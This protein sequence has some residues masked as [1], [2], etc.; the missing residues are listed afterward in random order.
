MEKQSIIMCCL[1]IFSRSFIKHA[2]FHKY[3]EVQF[4]ILSESF[5]I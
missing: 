1:L 4:H 3:L 5:V 2:L